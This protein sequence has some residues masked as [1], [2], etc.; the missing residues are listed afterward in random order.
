APRDQAQPDSASGKVA[1][2]YG[3]INCILSQ[4]LLIPPARHDLPVDKNL[5]TNHWL[6]APAEPP[7]P[8][9]K[10]PAPPASHGRPAAR[11]KCGKTY[12]DRK[13]TRLNSSHVKI[14]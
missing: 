6:P 7:G 4:R 14:S 2:V 10:K 8:V 5:I 9:V 11:L 12:R 3:G 1:A 13:S